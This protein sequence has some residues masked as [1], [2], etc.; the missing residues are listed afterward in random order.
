[1]PIK[2]WLVELQEDRRPNGKRRNELRRCREI[3][4]IEVKWRNRPSLSA[5]GVARVTQPR[6]LLRA[7]TGRSQL[8]SERLVFN[9]C[10]R[11]NRCVAANRE[12]IR[13][14]KIGFQPPG[15]MSASATPHSLQRSQRTELLEAT[16]AG[17]SV[18]VTHLIWNVEPSRDHQRRWPQRD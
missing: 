7:K 8:Q 15:Q 17:T 10:R 12:L 13:I 1:M 18:T 2:Q 11:F 6:G 3:D 16:R 14:R 5:Q 4:H 9:R